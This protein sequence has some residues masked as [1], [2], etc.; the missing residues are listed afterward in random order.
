M[1]KKCIDKVREYDM[2]FHTYIHTYIHGL[3]RKYERRVAY[4]LS[5]FSLLSPVKE[6]NI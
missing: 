5:D 3:R 6:V 4:Y 2:I 1:L